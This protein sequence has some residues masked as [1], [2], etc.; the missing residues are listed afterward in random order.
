VQKPGC[1][2]GE[3]RTRLGKTL[4]FVLTSPSSLIFEGGIKDELLDYAETSL[5]FAD[6]KISPQIICW[7]RMILFYG[8]TLYELPC[9]SFTPSRQA[10]LGQG[11]QASARR[12]HTSSPFGSPAAMS[13]VSSSR[14]TP[15]HS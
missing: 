14:S 6:V 8:T 10:L 3:V 11:R 4:R 12:W 2:V 5:L 7:N 1:A 15:T 9:A 13:T